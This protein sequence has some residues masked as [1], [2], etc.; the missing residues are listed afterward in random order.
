MTQDGY[1]LSNEW[2][3]YVYDFLPMMLTLIVCITWYDP[4]IKP[5]KVAD[6]EYGMR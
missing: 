4:N 5:K 2:P 6:A 1:L 3:L